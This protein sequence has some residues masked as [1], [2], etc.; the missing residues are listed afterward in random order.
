MVHKKKAD[1]LSDEEWL[2]LHLNHAPKLEARI[3]A[4]APVDHISHT[5][6]H[7]GNKTMG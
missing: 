7:K 2:K 3:S 6:I 5:Y 1:Q 4:R